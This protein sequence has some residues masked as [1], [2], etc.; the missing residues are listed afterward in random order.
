MPLADKV[1]RTRLRM[2]RIPMAEGDLIQQS[3]IPR[4]EAPGGSAQAAAWSDDA[5]ASVR[6]RERL[7]AAAQQKINAG[8]HPNE[9]GATP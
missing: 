2:R 4:R 6:E 1:I 8:R 3:A 9:I 5:A 7:Q